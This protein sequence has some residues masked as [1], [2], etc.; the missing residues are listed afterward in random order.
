MA[1]YRTSESAGN[2]S[3][4]VTVR[5]RA[6]LNYDLRVYIDLLPST[7]TGEVTD[8]CPGLYTYYVIGIDTGLV[9]TAVNLDSKHSSALVLDLHSRTCTSHFTQTHAHMQ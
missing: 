9:V 3:V 4:C 6:T 5:D 2:V 7:A 8:L 1:E